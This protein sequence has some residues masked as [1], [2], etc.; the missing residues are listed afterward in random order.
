MRYILIFSRGI[1]TYIAI[2]EIYNF[3][4]IYEIHMEYYSAE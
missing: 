2:Y 4:F 3:I 1:H